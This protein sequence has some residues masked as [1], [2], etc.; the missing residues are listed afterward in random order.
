MY[1]LIYQ[2]DVKPEKTK[3]FEAAWVGLTKLIYEFEGSLGSRLHI[4]E[5][6]NYIAYA[7]W[8]SKDVFDNAGNNMPA[9]ADLFRKA[10]RESC[11][12]IKTLYKLDEVTDLLKAEFF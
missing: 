12:E 1:C 5:N 8:P 10:M 11:T 9:E 2:F 7:Q 3:E 6:G 4:D